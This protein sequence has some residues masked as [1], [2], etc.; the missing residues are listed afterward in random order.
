MDIRQAAAGDEA[1]VAQ[2]LEA[3]AAALRAKGRLIWGPAEIN[4]DAVR[5]QVHAG[6]YHVASDERGVAG[7]FRIQWEDQDFWP[8]M[9]AGDAAYVHKVAVPPERQGQGIPH[10]LL[11]HA[12]ALARQQGRRWLRLDCMGGQPGLRKVYESFG[13]RHHSD[14]PMGPY[15]FHRFELDLQE[16]SSGA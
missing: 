13:F 12:A 10:L 11:A 9:A 2:V 15:T 14:K 6:M 7:V 5:A 8:E 3:A 4:E 16:A 1:L